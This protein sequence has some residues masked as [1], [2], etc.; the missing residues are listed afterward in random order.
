VCALLPLNMA[1]AD[2][3]LPTLLCPNFVS[4]PSAALGGL[5]KARTAVERWDSWRRPV[6][7][8]AELLESVHMTSAACFP[9]L[10][11]RAAAAFGHEPLA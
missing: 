7:G 1:R 4:F 2:H 9:R 6:S 3:I 8:S 11:C 5:L 10:A